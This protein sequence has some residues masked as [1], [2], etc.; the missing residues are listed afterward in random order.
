MPMSNWFAPMGGSPAP[1]GGIY[2]CVTFRKV[3][4]GIM[5]NK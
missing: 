3:I 2:V 5:K 1:I 4:A